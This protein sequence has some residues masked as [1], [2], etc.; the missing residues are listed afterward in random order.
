MVKNTIKNLEFL[1][2]PRNIAFM[3]AALM[4]S[5]LPNTSF[6]NVQEKVQK[7]LAASADFM[8]AS[9]SADKR[10]NAYK[11]AENELGSALI[12]DDCNCNALAG[13]GSL[14]SFAGKHETAIP[15]LEKAVENCS[16]I[17]MFTSLQRLMSSYTAVGN[18]KGAEKT[19]ASALKINDKSAFVHSQKGFVHW[20]RK[21]YKEAIA[22]YEKTIAL[23]QNDHVV[24]CNL[25]MI[26]RELGNNDNAIKCIK[27]SLKI[28]P[29]YDNGHFELGIAYRKAGSLNE[30]VAELTRAVELAPRADNFKE[31]LDI[32]KDMLE[33]TSKN[34]NKS[35]KYPG[36]K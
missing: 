10:I 36:S 5:S 7:G 27:Q 6:G 19:I 14:Q 12:E 13:Y 31:E 28:K 32:T 24:H 29:D 15:T 8:N 21:E 11:I 34:N 30:A 16:G 17:P 3:G 2:K 9:L 33:K 18:L 23:N 1:L 4:A 35:M 25:G 20:L 22:D 26:Y